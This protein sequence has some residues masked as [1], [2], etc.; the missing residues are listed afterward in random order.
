MDYLFYHARKV[1]PLRSERV[2][3]RNKLLINIS[4][5]EKKLRKTRDS[6]FC[7]LQIAYQKAEISSKKKGTLPKRDSG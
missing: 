5:S 7:Q 6:G 2:N 4:E 3:L 1:K